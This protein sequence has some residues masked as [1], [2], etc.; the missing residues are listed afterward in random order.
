MQHGNTLPRKN[1]VVIAA[2]AFMALGLLVMFVLV[3][4]NV[5]LRYGFNSGIAASEDLARFLFIWIIF[6]GAALGVRENAHLGMDSVIKM[7]PRNG[8]VVFS[9]ISHVL[10]LATTGFLLIGSWQ[11]ME[12]NEGTTALGAVP[13]PLSWVY[14][15]GIYGSLAIG[16]LIAANLKRILSGRLTDAELV[17]V[18]DAE[19]LQQ[20]E[21]IAAQAAAAEERTPSAKGT[22]K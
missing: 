14:V 7:L 20:A 13:Y 5:V 17:M 16:F 22:L 1:A 18:R 6:T 15:A 4:G 3:L 11:Q 21:Q 10:M 2:E 19:G 9:I 12:L 8:K